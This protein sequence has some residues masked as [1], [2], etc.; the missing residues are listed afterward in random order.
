MPASFYVS[1]VE[2]P[3]RPEEFTLSLFQRFV[4]TVH[5]CRGYMLQFT[6]DSRPLALEHGTDRDGHGYHLVK[7]DEETRSSICS[8]VFLVGQWS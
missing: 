5:Y 6:P 1:Q 8:S 2:W 3:M 7:F 4:T